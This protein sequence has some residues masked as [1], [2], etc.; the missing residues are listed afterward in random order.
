MT[1]LVSLLP[2]FKAESV[3]VPTLKHWRLPDWIRDLG[4]SGEFQCSSVGV[5]LLQQQPPLFEQGCHG[6]RLT[7]D[8]ARSN[9]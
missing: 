4:H 3:G 6:S 9:L 5:H 1:L 8:M 2:V 7:G